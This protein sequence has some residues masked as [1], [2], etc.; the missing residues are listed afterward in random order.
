MR[1]VLLS[2]ATIGMLALATSAYAASPDD[3]VGTSISGTVGTVFS[4]AF[5][6]DSDNVTFTTPAAGLTISNIDPTE[7]LNYLDGHSASKS[8]I[9]VICKSNEDIAWYLK[10]TVSGSLAGKM[11]YYMPQ[12]TVDQVDTNGALLNPTPG[13]GDPLPVIPD[14]EAIYSSGNDNINTP[15]GTYCGMSLG[16]N[17]GGLESGT[18]QSGDITFT[19]T[20]TP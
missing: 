6:N 16:V 15:N 13:L 1:K 17:G 12:P 10:T 20:Q 18:S 14:D 7:S 3:S 11:L 8:D 4:I 5:D 19:M 9:A 2:I